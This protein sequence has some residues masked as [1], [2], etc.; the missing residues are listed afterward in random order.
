MRNVDP[1]VVI[2]CA[3]DAAEVKLRLTLGRRGHSGAIVIDR[4]GSLRDS[5]EQQ[6]R[7]HGLLPLAVAA[8]TRV[9]AIEAIEAGAD[10]AMAIDVSS[11][12]EVLELMDRAKLRGSMRAQ[13]ARERV[14]V[15]Q[16][17]KLAALGTL[18]AGVAHEI[19]TP[20]GA[21]MLGLDILPAQL[22][23]AA[24][25]AE[26][27]V[28]AADRDRALG[29]EDVLRIAALGRMVG[30]R[31]EL[32][33]DVDDV[34]SAATTIADVVKDLRVF[35]RPDD[36]ETPEVVR[37]VELI[38]HL[39]RLMGREIQ[40]MAIIERD[41]APDVPEVVLPLSRI[42][43]VLTN[44]LVNATHAM[45]EVSRDVHRMRIAIRADEQA[46][47]LSISDTGPG[48]PPDVIERI[49]DPF[50]TTKRSTLGTGLGL[51]ISR[52]LMR[53]MNGD[54]L[55]D[56]VFGEGA[57]FVLLIPRATVAEIRAARLRAG[58]VPRTTSPDRRISVLIVGDSD[59]LVR[60]YSRV[61]GRRCD[62][63]I[64]SDAEE[65]MQ[66]LASGSKPDAILCDTGALDTTALVSWLV[67]KRS[68]LASRLVVVNDDPEF[69]RRAPQLLDLAPEIL[70]KPTPAGSLIR[71]VEIVAAR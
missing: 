37:L 69:L 4:I 67:E 7:V 62:V 68:E 26:E 58:I 16:A 33:R 27:V 45:R 41:I 61:L 8:R 38:D 48:I 66:M 71:A 13:Q 18:V 31:E 5:I 32:L 46:V 28:R 19:N 53:K 35:A 42:T 63:L 56:S 3:D 50:F 55:V 15:A 59:H 51:S 40:S 44:V 60:A 11:P 9:E 64:A 22:A 12:A 52:N 39:L 57:T 54:L 10:E 17:E 30:S 65:A 34:R 1:S 29:K 25:I 20:L 21:V 24:D 2:L 14:E 6:R 47:A 43:Q 70:S 23:A 36:R 49:F